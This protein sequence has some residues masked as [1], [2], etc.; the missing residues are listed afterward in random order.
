M[1]G[2]PAEAIFQKIPTPRGEIILRQALPDDV[3][4]YRQLRLEALKN[5]P[6]AYTSDYETSL[7][8]P[9]ERWAE[10]LGGP[11]SEGIKTNF[12]AWAGGELVAMGGIFRGD[13]PKT[14]HTATIVGIYVRP[15]W[16]GLHLSDALVHACEAW[17]AR[18]GIRILKLAVMSTNTPALKAYVRC[19]Y[20]V[21]GVDP[22]AVFTGG[23]YHDEILMTRELT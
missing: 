14:A 17:A 16:R 6:E 23:I 20:K 1:I 7:A 13:S 8:W 9:P 11:G 3:L 4:A 5:H 12:L 18:L 10:R 2:M 15:E 19:G 22:R 21:Y